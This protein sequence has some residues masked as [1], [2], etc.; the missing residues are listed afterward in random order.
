MRNNITDN[1]R[2]MNDTRLHGVRDDA[3]RRAPQGAPAAGR[4]VNGVTSHTYSCAPALLLKVCIEN[5]VYSYA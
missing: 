3:R 1:I 4:A 2:S 5:N